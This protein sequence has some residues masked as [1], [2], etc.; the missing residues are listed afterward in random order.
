MI[1]SFLY[2][3]SISIAS[4]DDDYII[5][6]SQPRAQCVERGLDT[7]LK[8][9]KLDHFQLPAQTRE[10]FERILRGGTF[11]LDQSELV[12]TISEEVAKGRKRLIFKKGA[13]VE[14][15]TSFYNGTLY[16]GIEHLNSKYTIW[17][18]FGFTVP[19]SSKKSERAVPTDAPEKAHPFVLNVFYAI[20]Q[21]LLQRVQSDPSIKHVMIKAHQV[22]NEAL[23]KHLSSVYGFRTED[24]HRVVDFDV[25]SR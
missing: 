22:N 3:I 16:I 1:I 23:A 12:R 24:K 9:S 6:L 2:F 10:V 7:E 20:L 19:G 17:Q 11:E 4:S 14:G 18:R 25:S 15:Y 21:G 13:Y 8:V 5:P